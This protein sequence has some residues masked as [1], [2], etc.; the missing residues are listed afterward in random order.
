MRL[1]T[2]L[3]VGAGVSLGVILVLGG[4]V[5]WSYLEEGRA[6]KEE[7]LARDLQQQAMDRSVIRDE[8]LL[9]PE[10]RT[11][12]QM[13][14]K[15]AILQALLLKAQAS[16]HERGDREA[17]DDLAGNLRRS[18]ELF[19]LIA[20]LP[21]GLAPRDGMSSPTSELRA[22]LAMQV[23]RLSRETHGLA[24]QLVTAASLRAGETQRRSLL[25]VLALATAVL[26]V[27]AL[28]AVQIVQLI[29]RRIEV[30]REGAAR[31]AAGDLE[32]RIALVGTD[33]LADLARAFDAMTLRL[34]EA[35]REREATHREL[36]AFSYSVSHDLRAPLRHLTGFAGLLREHAPEK[37]DEKSQHYLDVIERAATRMG[38]L[39]DDLLTFSRM[40]RVE[41]KPTRFP[42]GAQIDDVLRDLAPDAAG[43]EMVWEIGPLPEV[44]GDQAMLRQVWLNLV[45]NALK[46]TRRSVP[47]R[48]AI[49]TEPAPP[50]EVCV[51]VRDNGVGF[52]MK[53]AGKLFQV[54]QRLHSVEDF[55]G[56]G[57]GLAN[58][59]R[60]VH[61][62]GG[63]VWAE[64]VPDGG[65]TFRVALPAKE[66]AT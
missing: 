4:L 44:S 2:R 19:E 15:T 13:E 59:Q 18:T 27:T 11:R 29:D 66:D 7:D 37:L 38:T 39:I 21:I 62:H 46:F 3:R 23:L 54:F 26:V 40:G 45:G 6:R 31:V 30:L 51:F 9:Q 42:L 48:I 24:G 47:A 56:T 60:I 63:R 65:A 49:G 64:G 12:A 33:E 1:R 14:E 25:L 43:R 5:A 52:D 53:Y 10:A 28:N 41:M 34:R 32:H 16:F 35:Q 50:G 22:R 17:L 36:E 61:R 57:I 8:Y 58:V 55:E 20:E